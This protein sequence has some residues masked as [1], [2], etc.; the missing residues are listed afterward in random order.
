M[1]LVAGRR[2]PIGQRSRRSHRSGRQRRRWRIADAYLH[3]RAARRTRRRRISGLDRRAGAARRG[4]RSAARPSLANLARGNESRATVVRL[5]PDDSQRP[6]GIWDVAK[7]A[8]LQGRD[9]GDATSQ[10]Q[11]A[12]SSS[13]ADE[14]ASA[15]ADA[16]PP[17]D[18]W[19]M[20]AAGRCT[21][22]CHRTSTGHGSRSK[23]TRRSPT[24]TSSPRNA[25]AQGREART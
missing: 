15:F 16:R 9:V 24:A 7:L 19:R 4:V 6:G 13:R 23:S 21:A 11:D 1:L 14:L 12:V 17:H 2:G 22:R 20:L 3:F 25:Y 5:L 18:S 10:P 8:L